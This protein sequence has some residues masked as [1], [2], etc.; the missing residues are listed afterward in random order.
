MHLRLQDF[1]KE[2]NLFEVTCQEQHNSRSKSKQ[3]GSWFELDWAGRPN[4]SMTARHGKLPTGT[5]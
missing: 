4:H 3:F 5:T 1:E 2:G